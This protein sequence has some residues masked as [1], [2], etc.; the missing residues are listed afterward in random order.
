LRYHEPARLARIDIQSWIT[1]I[2]S[3]L[4]NNF[5]GGAQLCAEGLPLTKPAAK[6]RV[7]SASWHDLSPKP[8]QSPVALH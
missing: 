2:G 1:A 4:R 5:A 8:L 7:G 6:I 3:L